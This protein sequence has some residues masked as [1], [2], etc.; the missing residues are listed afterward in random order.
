[1]FWSAQNAEFKVVH[2][3]RSME[4]VTQRTG[5]CTTVSK[6]GGPIATRF[7]DDMRMVGLVILRAVQ[8]ALLFRLKCVRKIM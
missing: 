6:C 5:L 3:T 7:L 1:M 2:V 8:V 4:W